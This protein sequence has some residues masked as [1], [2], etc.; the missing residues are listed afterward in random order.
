MQP[1]I[2]E[3]VDPDALTAARVAAQTAS[4]TAPPAS[5]GRWDRWTWWIA[6]ALATVAWF[7]AICKVFV[8]DVDQYVLQRIW[9]AGGWL[10]TYRFF[11]LLVVASVLYVVPQIYGLE[12]ADQVE[13]LALARERLN[14]TSG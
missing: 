11:I 8:F 6:N 13:R 4:P 14:A 12:A 9:P 10:V 2:W 3:R 1:G 5:T 7:Y